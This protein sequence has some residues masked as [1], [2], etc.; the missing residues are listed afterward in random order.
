MHAAAL[1]LILTQLLA[2]QTSQPFV[3]NDGQWLDK[4]LFVRRG[5]GSLVRVTAEALL[6]T[7]RNEGRSIGLRLPS[8][9]TG[10]VV[11]GIDPR[12]YP[13]H[14]L[15]GSEQA[16]WRTDVP[17]YDSVAFRALR[18]GLDLIVRPESNMGFDLE[19]DVVIAPSTDLADLIFACETASCLAPGADGSL[20]IEGHDTG[21]VVIFSAVQIATDGVARPV[22]AALRLLG[23]REFALETGSDDPSSTLVISAG[24]TWSTFAAPGVG[25][26][27]HGVLTGVLPDGSIVMFEDLF[28]N[29]VSGLLDWIVTRIDSTG[30]QVLWSTQI[31]GREGTESADGLEVRPDEI[32]LAGETSSTDYPVTANGFDSTIGGVTDACVM[33]LAIDGRSAAYSTFLGSES[34]GEFGWAARRLSSGALLV[35][36][37]TGNADFPTTTGALQEI[38]PSPGTTGS[39]Q[40]GFVTCIAP[41]GD[42]LVFSTFL[43]GSSNLNSILDAR[44]AS[45]GS[46]LIVGRTKSQDFPVPRFAFDPTNEARSEF[47]QADAFVVRLS[48]DGSEILGGTFLGGDRDDIATAVAED[49]FGRI[50]V[51]GWTSSTAGFPTTRGAFMEGPPGSLGDAFVAILD[52]G[53]TRLEV[54][55]LFGGNLIEGGEV[56]LDVDPSGVVTIFGLTTTQSSNFPTTPGALKTTNLSTGDHYVARFSPA[57]DRLYYSTLFGG[58]LGKESHGHMSVT[59]DGHAEAVISGQTS[60]P[61]FPI[62]AGAAYAANEGG[63][64]VARLTLLPEGVERLGD[65][66]PG[67]HGTPRLMVAG[68]PS[69]GADDFVLVGSTAP[70]LSRGLLLLGH[71]ALDAPLSIRGADLFVDPAGLF[72]VR[73][74]R[75]DAAGLVEAPRRIPASP[76]LVGFSFV[77]QMLWPSECATPGFSATPALRVV[78]QP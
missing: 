66:T 21:R 53:M 18:P 1:V 30:T 9:A 4:S 77:A 6:V 48:P 59:V 7:E 20:R 60:S 46:F 69:L 3:R 52:P 55:T 12:S 70:R 54:S 45:D 31:G 24:L 37:S 50:V 44:E 39:G 5:A 15:L 35:A 58:D 32:L 68:M 49:P 27:K 17:S 76:D 71:D 2:A 64:Y 47:D 63:G 36:G 23:E 10:R 40:G 34:G 57:L 14:F 67:C 22:P 8:A 74:L 75:S 78:V 65:P 61:D 29:G 11:E 43:A 51:C 19:F 62:T 33:S 41:S 38:H 42:S 13:H 26:A 28:Q 73:L 56:A 16:G 25:G 72:A